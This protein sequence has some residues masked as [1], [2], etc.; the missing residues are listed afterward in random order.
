MKIILRTFVLGFCFAALIQGAVAGAPPPPPAPA[1]SFSS[2]D[3]TMAS[4]GLRFDFGDMKPEIVGQV[5]HTKTNSSNTVTGLMGEIAL[6]ILGE[7]PFVP[8]IRGMGIVGKPDVQGM[9]GLG[10]DFASQQPLLGLGVQGPFVEGGLN[11]E[12]GGALEPYLGVNSYD[13]APDRSI[14]TP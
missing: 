5:R 14:D 1:S 4:I 11:I 13:G 6:P 12:L 3:D 2:N 8:T 7:K 10:Y 9:V